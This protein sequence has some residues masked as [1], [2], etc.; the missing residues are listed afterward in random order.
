MLIV[1]MSKVTG[2]TITDAQ[3]RAVRRARPEL[4]DLLMVA[5]HSTVRELRLSARS[6]FATI[7]NA[8][9][10]GEAEARQR[11]RRPSRRA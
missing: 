11:S 4:L 1:K 5:I 2:Q 7:H 8:S 10:E 9:L 3:I 6:S